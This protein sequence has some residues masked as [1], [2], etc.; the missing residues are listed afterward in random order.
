MPLNALLR[1]GRECKIPLVLHMQPLWVTK[2][3]NVE[4]RMI[5]L[6]II[7]LPGKVCQEMMTKIRLLLYIRDSYKDYKIIQRLQRL[8]S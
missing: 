2:A 1:S 8:I 4:K 3:R 5:Y 7:F 6:F